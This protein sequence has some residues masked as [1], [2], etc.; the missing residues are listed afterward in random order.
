MKKP[1][2][3]VLISTYNGEKYLSILLDSLLKQSDVE[4][5]IIIRDDGSKDATVNI[6]KKYIINNKNITLVQ[7]KNLGYA[8][9]FWELIKLAPSSDYYAFCD[10]DDIWLNNKLSAA[11]LKIK[12]LKQNNKPILY[13]SRVISV[14]NNQTIIKKNTFNTS[15]SLNVYESFQKSVVPG[16][17]FVFNKEAKELLKIYD[18][19]MES[20]DW[21]AYCIINTFGKVL[22]DHNSYIYYRIHENNTIGHTNSFKVFLHKIQRF[23]KKSKNSRSKFA[24]D[25]FECYKN[26]IPKEYYDEIRNLAYYRNSIKFKTSL[27]LSSKFKGLVFKIY[28]LLNKI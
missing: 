16:C 27:F 20:H 25:F 26:I 7:G 23:F 1:I 6:I 3:N 18:G 2:V 21:A 19:Y 12:E 4:I 8:R 13:T 15:R 24:R 28:V 14:N 17:T 9:S 22:Y 5:Y 11:I 10:Q